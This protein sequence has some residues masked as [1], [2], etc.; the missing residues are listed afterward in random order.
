MSVSSPTATA[1]VRGTTVFFD[2]KNLGVTGGTVA[3]QGSRGPGIQVG[4]GFSAGLDS[5]GKPSNPVFSHVNGGG[6][7]PSGGG[8]APTGQAGSDPS[9][10]ASILGSGSFLDTSLGG[11]GNGNGG[12][13]GGPGGPGGPNGPGEPGGP[14]GGPGTLPPPPPPTTG[15][16]NIEIL[17]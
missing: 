17:Y 8:L 2:G 11:N 9:S 15:D 16:I 7:Q 10:G 4:N 13:P 12:D 3:F 6:S 14:V 1:S 5:T